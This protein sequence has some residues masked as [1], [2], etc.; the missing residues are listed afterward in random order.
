MKVKKYFFDSGNFIWTGNIKPFFLEII[1]CVNAGLAN[2]MLNFFDHGENK[3]FK[4]N[5]HNF[6]QKSMAVI[7]FFCPLQCFAVSKITRLFRIVTAGFFM[8]LF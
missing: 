8:V 7:S 4:I 3:C 1:I 6:V 2:S 5:L